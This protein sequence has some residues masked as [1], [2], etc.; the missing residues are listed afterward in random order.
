[1]NRARTE[2]SGGRKIAKKE[3]SRYRSEDPSAAKNV[4]GW[5]DI[6]AH[7]SWLCGD[8]AGKFQLHMRTRA[9]DKKRT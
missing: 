1:M 6:R 5:L 4:T 2:P 7:L 9:V 8:K 3:P